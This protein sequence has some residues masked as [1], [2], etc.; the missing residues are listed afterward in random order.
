MLTQHFR[1]KAFRKLLAEQ[2]G[3]DLIEYSL[4]AGFVAVASA[5][6]FPAGISSELARIMSAVVNAL[7]TMP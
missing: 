4:L 1:T 6:F 3:Q 5:A 7:P 2:A